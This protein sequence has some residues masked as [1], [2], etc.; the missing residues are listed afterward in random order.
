MDSTEIRVNKYINLCGIASR[1]EADEIIAAGRVTINGVIAKP[2]SKIRLGDNVCID[3]KRIMPLDKKRILAFYK[4]LGVTCTRKDEH[5]EVTLNKYFPNA[6]SLTYA[7]RLD[8]DSEGLL[9]MT[10]DGELAGEMMHGKAEH[11]KEYVV[12]LKNDVTDEFL[13]AFEKGVYL[14]ELGVTTKPCRIKKL[15]KRRVTIILTQGL[16]RQIR[17]MCSALG[18][19][20][21]TLKR[22]RV[23]NILLDD[24]NPGEYREISEEEEIVLRKTIQKSKSRTL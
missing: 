21:L 1:R 3:G 5:A 2:G 24:L 11:E 19:E 15:G 9:I 18:N 13:K 20:V 7:G 17:R 8:K 6:G 22:I 12:T 10:D 23:V 16:N 4:P 14:K